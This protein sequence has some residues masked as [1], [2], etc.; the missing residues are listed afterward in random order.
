MVNGHAQIMISIPKKIRKH[1]T[2]KQFAIYQG[3]ISQVALTDREGI[4]STHH[5]HIANTLV[6][7]TS[8]FQD[9]LLMFCPVPYSRKF[10]HGANRDC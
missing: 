8:T 3:F 6:P 2:A 4:G 5:L 9:S 1:H 7:S 10:S